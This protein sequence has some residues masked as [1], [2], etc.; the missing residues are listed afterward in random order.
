M[1]PFLQR[2]Q[3]VEAGAAAS[4]PP[5]PD[6]GETASAPPRTS[7][8]VQ[9]VKSTAWVGGSSLTAIL[10]GVVRVKA[11]AVLLGP[12]GFG[13][14][15]MY[16][17][18]SSF[19]QS[20][21]GMGINSSGV[22]QVAEA[23][24]SEDKER[25][26]RTAAVLAYTSAGLGVVGAVALSVFSGPVSEFTFGDRTHTWGICLMS[27]AV[28]LQ[29]IS[30]GQGAVLQGMRRIAD[31]AKMG[32]LSAV[33]GTAATI[34][35]VY[36]FRER[37]VVPSLVG[38][39]A[40][41]LLVSWAY[42]RKLRLQKPVLTAPVIR[43]EAAALIKLG[44]A[45]M[46]G[47]VLTM[48]SAYIIR[49]IVLRWAGLEATGLYQSAWTL[50]GLYLGIIL[51]SMGADFYPRLTA[52]IKD[53]PQCNRLVNEQAR[54]S[55]LLAGPGVAGTLTFAPVVIALCYS[56]TFGDAV[57]LLRW[58]CL[59]IAM[60][61]ISW[62]LGFIIIAAGRQRLII[63][64]EVAWTAVYLV[65]AWVCVAHF[66]LNGS[67]IAFFGSYVFHIFL[68]YSVVSRMVGFRWSRENLHAGYGYLAMIGTVFGGFYLLSA[69]V[70]MAVGAL[71]VVLGTCYSLRALTALLSPEDLP[72]PLRRV[73]ARYP[74]LCPRSCC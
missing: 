67:G 57:P 12:G 52:S 35:L 14:V 64:C 55:L 8:Y 18:V 27:L 34:A 4:P 11:L 28:L 24:G 41:S 1:P 44:S 6:A 66:G 29:L 13:L 72:L 26:A 23:A 36:V 3:E 42:S 38:V 58:L 54:V 37:G 7:S 40:L 47:G 48:G 53:H 20:V 50:G 17:S 59:G 70:A 68:T 15:G 62:P 22:R 56:P 71:V 60:R 65:L 45:F 31:L 51:Q 10:I 61:V 33:L 69:P 21:A 74:F 5:E 46:V 49:L 2:A 16:M 39:S 32:A 19:V 43:E 25:V 9:I 73:F 63:L 30:A